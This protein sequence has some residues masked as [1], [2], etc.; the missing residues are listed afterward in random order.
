MRAGRV[1]PHSRASSRGRALPSA[2]GWMRPSTSLRSVNNRDSL[3]PCSRIRNRNRNRN[4]N[5]D[6]NRNRNRAGTGTGTGTGPGAGTGAGAKIGAPYCTSAAW[7]LMMNC[8]RRFFARLAGV[9]FAR[10]GSS[11]AVALGLEALGGDAG[12]R[13][14][15]AYGF[16]APT[17]IAPCCARRRRCCRCDPAPRPA[18]AVGCAAVRR[19]PGAA[20]SRCRAG[21]RRCWS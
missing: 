13:E 14:P 2:R 7:R 20:R 6:R 19:P 21:S 12:A 11:A 8:T 9:L 18:R 17:A 3:K 1:H 15:V 16:G 4:R 10:I 5:R